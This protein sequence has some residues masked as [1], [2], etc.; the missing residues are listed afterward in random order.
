MVVERGVRAMILL[1]PTNSLCGKRQ[2]E[3]LSPREGLQKCLSQV[4]TG[5]C[6]ARVSCL[7]L[8]SCLQQSVL[9]LLPESTNLASPP[10]LPSPARMSRAHQH[11]PGRLLFQPPSSQLGKDSL[12]AH[13]VS[14]KHCKNHLSQ[15]APSVSLLQDIKVLES[16]MYMDGTVS[17]V[18]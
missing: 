6:V 18:I 2:M 16:S 11:G 13:T 3:K 8:G 10:A 17:P 9:C 12:P 1:Y 14:P 5:V 4:G 7:L 15:S